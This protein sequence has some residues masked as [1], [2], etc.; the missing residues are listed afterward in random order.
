MPMRTTSPGLE[1]ASWSRA[2]RSTQ[3]GLALFADVMARLD[4][5]V[6][7]Y[8]RS[9]RAVLVAAEPLLGELL[10]HRG[11]LDAM[12]RG[13]RQL[14]QHPELRGRSFAYPVFVP[15][16]RAYQLVARVLAP[17]ASTTIHDH[18]G[19]ALI[20]VWAGEEL[21]E[22]FV[23]RP[24]VGSGRAE[25]RRLT[26]HR[27][28]ELSGFVPGEGELHRTSNLGDRPAYSLHLLGPAVCV[29]PALDHARG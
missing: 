19:W 17:G 25:L 28:G 10:A 16:S 9:P 23:S 22:R 11:F 21:E 13:D 27:A 4:E 1:R 5:A 6:A 3:A 14:Q 15:S 18:A 12:C 2:H 24:E 26:C 8:A 29:C 20:G 7:V